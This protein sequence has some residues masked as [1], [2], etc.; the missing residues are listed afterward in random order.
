M[1]E[2]KLEQCLSELQEITQKMAD[3]ALPLEEAMKLYKKGAAAA[4][5]AEKLLDQAQQELEL[6]GG[7]KD[8][9]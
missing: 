9:T 8:G 5:Q 2:K 6:V 4:Q 1:A 7:L 3:E